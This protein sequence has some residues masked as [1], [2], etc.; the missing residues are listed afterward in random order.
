MSGIFV[1]T[2]YTIANTAAAVHEIASI[3]RAMP[4]C[5]FD[6][7]CARSFAATS[8]SMAFDE[9]AKAF[10]ISRSLICFAV[11]FGF[12]VFCCFILAIAAAC[13]GCIAPVAGTKA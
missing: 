6:R 5:I 3:T 10:L 4:K 11:N 8:L 1:P 9:V 13:K 12:F 7:F 2:K